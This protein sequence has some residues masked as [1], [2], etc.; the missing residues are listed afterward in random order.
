MALIECSECAGKV[1]DRA[2]ACPHCGAPP[3]ARPPSKN[4]SQKAKSEPRA[5]GRRG[6]LWEAVGFLA[7]V[8]GMLIGMAGGDS[9]FAWT[10]GVIGF[11]IFLIGRF[12]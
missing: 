2:E 10:L 3:A 9:G 12:Q 8:A 11:V 1:S 7:I 4:P 5:V 6:G